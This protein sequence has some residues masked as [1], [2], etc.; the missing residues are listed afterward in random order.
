VGTE[1]ITSLESMGSIPLAIVGVLWL[2][3]AGWSAGKLFAILGRQTLANGIPSEIVALVAGLHL[4][5]MAGVCIGMAGL[6]NGY[7][8]LILLSVPPLILCILAG[9]RKRSAPLVGLFQGCQ[10]WKLRRSWLLVAPFMILT[11]GPALNFPTGWDELVYHSVLPRRW[12]EDGW[13]AFYSDIPYSG[14]PSLVEILCWLVAPV[15]SLVASRLLI[16]IC[17]CFGLYLAYDTFR[18]RCD[19]TAAMCL[20]MTL[21]ASPISLLVSANCYVEAFQLLELFAILAVLRNAGTHKNDSQVVGNSILL[22]ILVGGAIAVKLTGV[23]CL[24]IPVAWFLNLMLQHKATARST[25]LSISAMLLMGFSVA[26]PFYARAWFY[27][28]NPLYPF[29]ADWF[30]SDARML[31][32]SHYHHSIGSDAFGMRGAIA[33]FAAPFMLAWD[34]SLYDGKFGFQWLVMMGIAATGIINRRAKTGRIHWVWILITAVLCHVFWFLSA[35]QARFAIPVLIT[36]SLLT[37]YGLEGMK[38]R[39]RIFA[40]LLLSVTTVVSLPWA[41]TGYY[42]ASWERLLGIWNKTQY[43]DDS[44]EIEYVPLVAEI[45][46]TTPVNARILLL[47]EHRSLYIPRTCTI[48]TPFFQTGGFSPPE[49]Y[50]DPR[51][52]MQFLQENG[53]THVVFA[54]KP[55]GPDRSAEWWNRGEPLFAAFESNIKNGFLMAKWSTPNYVLLEVQRK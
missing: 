23:V 42:L 30:S 50:A 45:E 26:F 37:C 40:L 35:Q 36:V 1:R 47:F 10:E 38:R 22:G 49:Q 20:A 33:F 55:I 43:V 52:I 7:R 6:L 51:R 11:F 12:L 44:L 48:G 31:E 5:A 8:S 24:V 9:F 13:P 29:F 54:T 3:L 27:A 2:L 25:F 15:E 21:A 53:Y 41:N 14:F 17:W 28:G 18:E 19:R 4:V 46:K 32:T 16:W 39:T 34:N